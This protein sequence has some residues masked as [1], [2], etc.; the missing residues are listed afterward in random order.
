MSYETT[1]VPIERS[2]GAI[3]LLLAHLEANVRRALRS[4][5]GDLF[6]YG[7]PVGHLVGH[8]DSDGETMMR[9]A[10]SRP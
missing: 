6:G 1:S 5:T 7:V 9:E 3:R 10:E 4:G 2:Q 8:L